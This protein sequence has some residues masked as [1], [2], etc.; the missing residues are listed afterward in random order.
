MPSLLYNCFSFSLKLTFLVKDQS[1]IM[2]RLF[3]D[4]VILEPRKNLIQHVPSKFLKS[5]P[6]I[7]YSKDSSYSKFSLKNS[8][9][10]SR[11]NQPFILHLN[12][13]TLP[14]KF[15]FKTSMKGDY[16]HLNSL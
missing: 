13:I 7:F 10:Y 11:H 2:R 12:G 16:Y 9:V 3:I 8:Y 5:M 15:K 4:Y 6:N 14:Y 1:R